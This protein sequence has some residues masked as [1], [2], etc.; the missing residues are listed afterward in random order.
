MAKDPANTEYGILLMIKSRRSRFIRI[1][2]S[3]YM[4]ILEELRE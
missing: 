2:E 1:N 3:N 4:V